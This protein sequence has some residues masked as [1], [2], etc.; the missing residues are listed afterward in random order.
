M[1][2]GGSQP[3]STK[4]QPPQ[5]FRAARP[6]PRLGLR[7]RLGRVPSK[8]PCQPCAPG[9]SWRQVGRLWDWNP[10]AREAHLGAAGGICPPVLQGERRR[11]SKEHPAP[12]SVRGGGR[13]AGPPLRT[14]RARAG[15]EVAGRKEPDPHNP[16]SRLLRPSPSRT[17]FPAHRPGAGPR[18]G[19]C[20]I[21][22]V[23]LGLGPGLPEPGSPAGAHTCPATPRLT[24]EGAPCGL[25]GL[26]RARS[27]GAWGGAGQVAG[28]VAPTAGTLPRRWRTRAKSLRGGPTEQAVASRVR[29]GPGSGAVR[30]P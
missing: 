8:R 22:E 1:G 11:G 7:L 5:A 13:S 18:D 29:W 4:V 23:T 19:E 26:Q 9:R 20:H 21:L 27:P 3:A 24:S 25:W 28:V 16:A 15:V 30:G 6:T 12:D 17:P 2:R 10:P 14:R